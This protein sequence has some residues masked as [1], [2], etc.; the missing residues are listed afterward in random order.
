MKLTKKQ[1]E[2]KLYSMWEDGEVP[3][4]FTEDHSEYERAVKQMMKLGYIIWED[5]F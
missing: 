1:A 3:S 5:F 2:E 4:N